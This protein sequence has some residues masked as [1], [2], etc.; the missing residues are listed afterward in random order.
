MAGEATIA[1]SRLTRLSRAV[2][3]EILKASRRPALFACI[4]LLV[5]AAGTV[6]PLGYSSERERMSQ[7]APAESVQEIVFERALGVL[8]ESATPCVT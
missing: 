4:V 1:P 8:A 3:S 6:G 7:S 5:L 2:R